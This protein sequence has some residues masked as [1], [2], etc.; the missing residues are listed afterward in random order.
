[1]KREKFS[2]FS[3]SKRCIH[4]RI[5]RNDK[6]NRLGIEICI[7]HIYIY[8]FVSIFPVSNLNG[9]KND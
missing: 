5:K 6:N 7:L 4:M 9:L 3:L 2:F 1:M 8:I